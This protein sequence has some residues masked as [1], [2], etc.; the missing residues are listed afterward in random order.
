[1][2]TRLSQTVI[3]TCLRLLS[4]SYSLI[5]LRDIAVK[6]SLA[7]EE[8]A[9]YVVAKGIRDGVVRGTVEHDKGRVR[10]GGAEGTE[11]GRGEGLHER[12]GFCLGLH[13]ESVKV[14]VSPSPSAEKMPS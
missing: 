5:S 4:L 6:L 12:I 8:D 2:I 10:W 11:E 9:E 1:M 3:R 14:G 13:N 7:S